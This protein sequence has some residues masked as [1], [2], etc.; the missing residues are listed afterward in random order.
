MKLLN[1]IVSSWFD[2]LDLLNLTDNTSQGTKLTHEKFKFM[3]FTKLASSIQTTDLLSKW[4]STPWMPRPPRT[5]K[6]SWEFS[7]WGGKATAR[8]YSLLA[9]TIK[10]L[11]GTHDPSNW[12]S[13]PLLHLH[14]RPLRPTMN[15]IRNTVKH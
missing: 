6:A 8:K 3:I 13:R 9:Y 5:G 14:S 7:P 12:S 2:N 15:R 11:W 1:Y 4:K 10:L